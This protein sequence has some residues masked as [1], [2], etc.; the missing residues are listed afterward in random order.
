M[1]GPYQV[2]NMSITKRYTLHHI[3]DALQQVESMEHL[4]AGLFEIFHK[5][6][7]NIYKEASKRRD[8][9][10]DELVAQESTF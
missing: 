2:S 7:K 4:D 9:A 1:F 8:W 6:F 10:T 3:I 5:V